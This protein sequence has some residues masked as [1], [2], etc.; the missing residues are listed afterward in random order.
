MKKVLITEIGKIINDNADIKEK[1]I[2]SGIKIYFLNIHKNFNKKT[3][4]T[5]DNIIEEIKLNEKKYPPINTKN[6]TMKRL[7]DEP[8]KHI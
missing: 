4:E 6:L 1:N 2:V 7:F 3:Q 8:F 5:F